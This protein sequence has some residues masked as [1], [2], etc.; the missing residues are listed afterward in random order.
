MSLREIIF[1]DAKS[2]CT[3]RI[4]ASLM[5][6]NGQTS[7]FQRFVIQLGVK[8]KTKFKESLNFL[9]ISGEKVEENINSLRK[10]C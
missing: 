10:R 1:Q 3:K 9:P 4:I 2:S 7:K 8:T 5:V 6:K